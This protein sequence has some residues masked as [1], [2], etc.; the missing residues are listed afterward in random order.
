MCFEKPRRNLENLE[1]NSGNPNF[2]K[3]QTGW[4][5][6]ILLYELLTK[7]IGKINKKLYKQTKLSI[8]FQG[9]VKVALTV[10]TK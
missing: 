8:R 5:T 4:W 1:K 7:Y 10:F 3:S 9:K 6:T 2:K